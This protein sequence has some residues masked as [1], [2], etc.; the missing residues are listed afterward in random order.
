[1]SRR[2]CSSPL[3]LR[4]AAMFVILMVGACPRAYAYEFATHAMFTRE[5]FVRSSLV[6]DPELVNRFG[7]TAKS[8]Q[9]SN[10]YIHLGAAGPAIRGSRP[11]DNPTFTSEK[12]D[13]ANQ[14]SANIK[15]K[16]E[17]IAGWLMQGAIREDDVLPE[18]GADDNTP[19]DDPEKNF[20]R[21]FN[22]FFN[23]YENTPIQFAGVSF[24]ERAPSWALVGTSTSNPNRYSLAHA[25]ESMWRAITLTTIDASGGLVSLVEPPG[26]LASVPPS[27][28]SEAHRDAYWA[29][30]FRALGDVVHLLQDMAQP[31]HTRGDN[32]AG[33]ACVASA[34]LS[35]HASYYENYVEA[36]VSARPTFTLKERIYGGLL[37]ADNTQQLR[38]PPLALSSYRI[39]DFNSFDEYFSAG[40]S[41]AS[42]TAKGL[43]NFSNQGF[44]SIGTNVASVAGAKLPM[45]PSAF[46]DPRLQMTRVSNPQDAAGFAVPGTLSVIRADVL[47]AFEPSSTDTK[48]VA[49]SSIG[50]FDERMR[51][52]GA[53]NFTLTHYN[54]ADQ[55]K[56]LAPRAI[57]YSAGVINRFFR[58]KLEL[59]APASGLIGITDQTRCA[60]LCSFDRLQ[61]RVRNPSN[62]EALSKGIFVAVATFRRNGSYLSDLA[63]EPGAAGFGGFPVRSLGDRIAVSRPV[64]TRSLPS[65][66]L[67]PLE[68]QTI[69]FDF[70][71]GIP[72]QATDLVVQ[73]AFRGT[74][75]SEADSI[76]LGA[77]NI[78]EPTFT[79]FANITDYV[80][81]APTAKYKPLPVGRYTTTDDTLNIKL[82]FGSPTAPVVA[83][84]PKLSAGQ[85]AQIATLTDRAVTNTMYV[86]SQSAHWVNA[87]PV[88]V[89]FIGAEFYSPPNSTIYDASQKVSLRRG[90]YR[91]N[92]YFWGLPAD[93]SIYTCTPTDEHCV[94][95]TL[96][97]LSATSTVPWTISF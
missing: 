14:S 27:L 81:D 45:P 42:L 87:S 37:V 56:L 24:G 63:G 58:G 30:T 79:G 26:L 16:L 38:A 17:S 49:L 67:G 15:P 12:I 71:A 97:A 64:D 80:W 35:G 54:Y 13:D 40:T 4:S 23:P 66:A 60:G 62:T 5:A 2:D 94:Q 20:N 76:A 59:S 78:S 65:A 3:N 1:M 8:N 83:T 7:L 44:Y 31:Q 6:N 69:T 50:P 48:A 88:P 43:A 75:G 51:T 96:P 25:R 95:G 55:I 73:V 46:A 68:E 84:I 9:L 33:A 22:H 52:K 72:I 47:D 93:G 41:L 86:E 18:L 70:S 85:H 92:Y 57:A 82:R 90:V 29:T 36:R 61:M 89:D 28:S 91:Q 74:A 10:I 39:P 21:V 11:K 77:L 19:Q 53:F 34:C 32:H